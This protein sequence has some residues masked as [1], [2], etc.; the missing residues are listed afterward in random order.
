MAR[1]DKKGFIHGR[2]GNN[3]YRQV[4]NVNVM[5]SAPHKVQQTAATQLRAK[6]FG[7][8]NNAAK[9][10]RP[11]FVS[12][13]LHA[14]KRIVYR[15]GQA[16][17]KAIRNGD[18]E[19]LKDL[20]QGDLSCLP[21]FQFNLNSPLG[22]VLQLKPVVNIQEGGVLSI[23]IPAVGKEDL[24]FPPYSHL[25]MI[26]TMVMAINFKKEF[27]QYLGYRD[28]FLE[29]KKGK[30]TEAEEWQLEEAAEANSI[31][32][33]SLSLHY[34]SPDGVNENGMLLNDKS[35]S[36]AELI[37]ALHIGEDGAEPQ[38]SGALPK[39]PL[40]GYKGNELLRDFKRAQSKAE[41]EG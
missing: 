38:D 1:I 15:L 20:H 28:I 39:H 35:F 7:L 14:D 24:F 25:C 13:A 3:V 21:G 30:S 16:V 5:Q 4:G 36:P 19:G 17:L 2:I 29:N 31:V 37:A 32:L 27:Y 8:A 33:A 11:V 23:N 18:A 40:F 26:R 6:E 41:K 9:V 10:L 22:N 12:Q 34:F